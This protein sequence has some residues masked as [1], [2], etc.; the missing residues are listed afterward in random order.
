MRTST[1]VLG[2]LGLV[3]VAG[4]GGHGESLRRSRGDVAGA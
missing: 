3:K 1:S 2:T 4:S